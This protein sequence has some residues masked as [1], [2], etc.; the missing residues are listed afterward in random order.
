[1]LASLKDTSFVLFNK[2]LANN[3]NSVQITKER[4]GFMIVCKLELIL[5]LN[6]PV[7]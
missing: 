3:F 4:K 1:M 7:M 5:I 6:M 2:V